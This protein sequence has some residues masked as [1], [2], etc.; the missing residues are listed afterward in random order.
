MVTLPE[1]L[2]QVL[3][4]GDP[5]GVLHQ[6]GDYTRFVLDHDYWARPERPVLGLQF[7]DDPWQE[8]ASSMRLPVWFSNLLPEGLLREWVARDRGVSAQREMELLARLGSDLPG[9]VTVVPDTGIRPLQPPPV[10]ETHVSTPPEGASGQWR[11]SLAGVGL[12]FS[13]LREG[14]RLTMPAGGSA[15]DWIV[16]MPDA[17]HEGVPL[18]EFSMMRWAAE[19]G[20]N[21]PEVRLVRRRELPELPERAWPLGEEVAY[22]IE[23]FD[24]SPGGGVVHIEDLAQVRGFLPEDEYRGDLATVAALLYR[25]RDVESLREFARRVT[26]NSLIGNGDAHLKNWS[27]YYPDRVTPAL[28]PVY[29]VVSTAPYLEPAHVEDSGLKFLGS[30]RFDEVQPQTFQRLQRRLGATGAALDDVSEA[31]AAAVLAG[32]T[33]ALEQL[34]PLQLVHDWLSAS[35]GENL[36]RFGVSS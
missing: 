29:D 25:G 7:E 4:H 10:V 12:K 30:R 1:R 26:F 20:I 11:S 3:L 19:C 33:A 2:H 34:K 36:R 14:D 27:L 31:T 18:N 32:S 24:R 17:V 9:A 15:G 35:L 16:K 5:V 13:M 21:V 23:R 22:A 6:W 8:R 28:A